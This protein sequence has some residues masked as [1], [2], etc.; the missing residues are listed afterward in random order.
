MV[1]QA[2]LQVQD[3]SAPR[4]HKERKSKVNGKDIGD[5]TCS[6]RGT[7]Q[8]RVLDVLEQSCGLSDNGM[9]CKCRESPNLS[10]KLVPSVPGM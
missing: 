2:P 5:A 3:P 1:G 10:N 6:K 7:F 8:S 9:Y 4:L